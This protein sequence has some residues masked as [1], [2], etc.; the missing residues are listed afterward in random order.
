MKMIDCYGIP[1]EF[2]RSNG[3]ITTVRYWNGTEKEFHHTKVFFV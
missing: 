1:C 2:V 3:L